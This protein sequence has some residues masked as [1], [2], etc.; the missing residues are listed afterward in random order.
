[1][2]EDPAKEAFIKYIATKKRPEEVI[3]F[4]RDLTQI[5]SSLSSLPSL[6][7]KGMLQRS[8]K[9][10]AEQVIIN[11]YNNQNIHNNKNLPILIINIM[12]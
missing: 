9:T 6:A 2:I 12:N 3:T 10:L 5:D 11:N 7:L 1:M 8:V 4:I